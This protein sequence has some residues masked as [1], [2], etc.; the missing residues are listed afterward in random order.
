MNIV[1]A[2]PLFLLLNAG[3]YAVVAQETE[4][5][6]I[7]NRPSSI[8]NRKDANGLKQGIWRKTYPEGQLKYEGNFVDDVPTGLFKYYY[9]D[10][11]L[12][13][14]NNYFNN[15]KSASAHIYYPDGKIKG[16]GLYTETK[17]D[18]LWKFYNSGEVLVAEEFYTRGVRNG[19]WKTYYDN[20]KPADETNWKNGIKDGQWKQYYDDG[21]LKEEAVYIKDKREGDYKVYFPEHKKISIEGKYTGDKKAGIW[22]YYHEDGSVER[23]EKYKDGNLNET[24]YMNTTVN[25]YY[26]NDIPKSSVTYKNGKKNGEWIEYYEAGEWKTR[27][28]KNEDGKDDDEGYIEGQKIKAKGIYVN[29]ELKEATWYNLDGTV[30]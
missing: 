6:L 10:G 29:G 19:T 20:G 4:L 3:L 8:I 2:I 28:I 18:S 22:Y 27:K 13:A 17:K 14:T 9:R 12:E 7:D 30:K 25:E 5:D 11:K 23:I 26:K 24:N 21:A 15:G 16:L 1:R